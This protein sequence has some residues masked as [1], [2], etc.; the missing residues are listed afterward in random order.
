MPVIVFS[1]IHYIIIVIIFQSKNLRIAFLFE[2]Y[3]HFSKHGCNIK[4]T[5]R[6]FYHSPLLTSTWFWYIMHNEK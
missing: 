4:G 2:R 3:F 5:Y 6:S 1:Q